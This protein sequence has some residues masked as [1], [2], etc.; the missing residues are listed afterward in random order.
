MLS[1]QL[2][3]IEQRLVGFSAYLLDL[4]LPTRPSTQR[5]IYATEYRHWIINH[6]YCTQPAESRR[7]RMYVLDTVCFGPFE[8][9][10]VGGLEVARI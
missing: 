2:A 10:E 8:A 7:E 5:W 4:W 3:W 9:G 6:G 1:Q